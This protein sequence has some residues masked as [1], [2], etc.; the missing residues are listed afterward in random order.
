MYQLLLYFCYGLAYFTLGISLILQNRRVV[1]SQLPLARPLIWLGM[2][3]L[4]HGLSEWF[5]LAWLLQ[6]VPEWNPHLLLGKQMLTVISYICL[7]YFG[8]R[9][10]E[11]LGVRKFSSLWVIPLSIAG[12]WMIVVA[13]KI[14]FHGLGSQ[15]LFS[16]HFIYNY[17]LG[18]PGAVFAGWGLFRLTKYLGRLGLTRFW[19]L[20]VAGMLFWGYGFFS[21]LLIREQSWFP[22]NVINNQVFQSI[23]GFPVEVVRMVIAVVITV[24]FLQVI[25]VFEWENVA[26]ITALRSRQAVLEERQRLGQDI[27]DHLVQDIFALSLHMDL[28][29]TNP[30]KI[31]VREL[32]SHISRLLAQARGYLQQEIKQ[33][34]QCSLIDRVHNYIMQ[35]SA[36]TNVRLRIEISSGLDLSGLQCDATDQ[37]YYIIQEAVTNALKHS[38]ASEIVIR[39]EDMLEGIEIHVSDNGHG[40]SLNKRKRGIG[41]RIMRQRAMEVGGHFSIETDENGTRVGLKLP[42]AVGQVSNDY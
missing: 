19:Q 41:I 18:F 22:A 34:E 25:Q 24:M 32:Q 29:A 38:E 15:V 20:K 14:Y 37:C 12:I 10:L 28:I 6:L 27:H 39:F 16:V 11:N 13:A 30:D 17:F 21:S 23:T 7:F 8:S 33:S 36:L 26:R 42:W 5:V 3:G 1:L 40:F 31:N 2:F 35:L 9:L 4:L